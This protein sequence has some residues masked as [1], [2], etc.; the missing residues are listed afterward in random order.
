MLIEGGQIRRS[1][2][3]K[4][5]SIIILSTAN[6]VVGVSDSPAEHVNSHDFVF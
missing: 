5:K 2:E 4:L 6:Q 3:N 1:P